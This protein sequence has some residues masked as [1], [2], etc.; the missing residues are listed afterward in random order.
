M[1]GGIGASVEAQSPEHAF[2]FGE[3]QGRYVLTAPPAESGGIAEEAKR[4]GVPL[5]RI[6]AT[7]GQTLKLGDAGPVALAAVREAYENWLPAFM[8][9]PQ[10]ANP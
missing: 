4:L 9:R 6:G 5:S 3:D 8:S 10:G 1:A 7:G 2:F